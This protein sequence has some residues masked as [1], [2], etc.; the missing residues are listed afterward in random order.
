MLN[1]LEGLAFKFRLERVPM[2]RSRQTNYNVAQS[3]SPAVERSQVEP[4]LHAV[5]V[6]VHAGAADAAGPDS[7][8]VDVVEIS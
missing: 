2:G 8:V 6:A 5:A 7:D 3:P 1:P 4:V